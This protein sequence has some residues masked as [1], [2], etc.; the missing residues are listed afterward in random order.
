VSFIKR[1]LAVLFGIAAVLAGFVVAVAVGL[2]TLLLFPLRRPAKVTMPG[3]GRS[4]PGGVIDVDATEVRSDRS[5][6]LS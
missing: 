6:T 2:L 3:G 5:Q 4:A 1:V